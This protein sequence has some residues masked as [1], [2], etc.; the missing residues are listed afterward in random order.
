[1]NENEFTPVDFSIREPRLKT[2]IAL[3]LAGMALAFIFCS[4]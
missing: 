3:Y 4:I 1:M 2:F